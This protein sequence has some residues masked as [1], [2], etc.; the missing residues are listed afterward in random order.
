[1]SEVEPLF[2]VADPAD[3][4]TAAR[5]LTD[6]YAIGA[7]LAVWRQH[8]VMLPPE[9]VVRAVLADPSPPRDALVAALALTPRGREAWDAYEQLL[10]RLA[11]ED[12]APWEVLGRALRTSKQGAQQRYERRQRAVD[13][14]VIH[15]AVLERP[16]PT[17][18]ARA[19]LD[20]HAGELRG[21]SILVLRHH[22]ELRGL[23]MAVAAAVHRFSGVHYMLGDADVLAAARQV[24]DAIGDVERERAD[25]PTWDQV[26][27][28][29]GCRAA[30]DRLADLVA[31][32]PR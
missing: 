19:W 32:A 15:Q 9:E 8:G 29:G 23:G 28:S 16:R 2:D 21:V 5:L 24:V 27:M 3:V 25:L 11:R 17:E 14:L 1:M 18:V 30:V 26:R 4:D 22:A 12:G 13:Q 31:T 7:D 10:M 6:R 20:E